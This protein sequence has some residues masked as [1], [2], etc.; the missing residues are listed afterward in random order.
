M[1]Q[2]TARQAVQ[3]GAGALALGEG[4]PAATTESPAAPLAV[5]FPGVLGILGRRLPIQDLIGFISQAGRDWAGDML[6]RLAGAGVRE[7]ARELGRAPSTISRELRRNSQDHTGAAVPVWAGGPQAAQAGPVQL[8]DGVLGNEVGDLP[9]GAPVDQD[10]QVPGGQ[11]AER[12]LPVGRAP[13]GVAFASNGRTL[14]VHNF[15][16]RTLGIY[17]ISRLEDDGIAD[18]HV[19]LALKVRGVPAGGAMD[20]EALDRANAVSG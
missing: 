3:T 18:V 8:V 20:P 7:I 12:G 15:M 17:D 11:P 4:Q 6:V 14:F 9:V 16:D 13:Q 1:I 5:A 2:S 10:Q 19:S